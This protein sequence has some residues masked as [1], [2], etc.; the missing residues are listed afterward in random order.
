LLSEENAMSDEALWS[1]LQSIEK[2]LNAIE[3]RQEKIETLLWDLSY[4]I[5][6][7]SQFGVRLRSD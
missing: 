5:K 2:Q 4:A 7:M 6:E 3:G 1:M